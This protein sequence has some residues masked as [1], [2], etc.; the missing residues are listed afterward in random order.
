MVWVPT[1]AVEGV[2]IPVEEVPGPLQVPPASAATNWKAGVLL[3]T[4]PT[5][6]MVGLGKPAC[7]PVGARLRVKLVEAPLQFSTTIMMF[8]PAT[9]FGAGTEEVQP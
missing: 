6:V 3:Q 7:A 8:W 9:T 4:G 5:G 2:K 1:P